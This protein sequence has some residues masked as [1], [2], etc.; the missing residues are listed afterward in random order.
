VNYF[1]LHVGDYEA[2]TAHLTMLED[3]AYGRMLRVYY[4]TEKPLPAD[5]AKV[6][7]LVRATTKPERDAVQAALDEFFA[8]RD[9]GWHQDR[10]N[11]EIER[12]Q[13]GEPE[14]E[15]KKVNEETRLKRHR[16]ERAALFKALTDAGKHAPWNTK[17]ETLRAMVKTLQE[18]A[19]TPPATQPAT[20][21][22]TTATATH[23]NVP[24][25]P[26]PH[27]PGLI[28]SEAKASGGEPP[29][30][31]DLRDVVFALGVPLLTSAGVKESN[32]RSFLA[33]QSKVHGDGALVSAL[34]RCAKEKPIQP[35]SW[36]QQVLKPK[37]SKHSGFAAKDYREG[38]T[39]DGHIA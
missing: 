18:A 3:A 11:A 28:P 15:A 23:G 14:R 32:A 31:P 10:C 25:L 9:D 7:R 30:P 35:V 4:R 29:T 39:E 37:A 33:M 26:T 2:A 20:A 21:P 19:A 27:S 12:F 16:E 13:A 17:I 34:E 36:L 6:C 8:L 24:P 22:A 5:V 1:E 38:V